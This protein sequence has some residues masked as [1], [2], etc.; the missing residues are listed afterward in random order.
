MSPGVGLCRHNPSGLLP[1]CPSLGKGQ[2][3]S[4]PRSFEQ[5]FLLPR[6]AKFWMCIRG[7][8]SISLSLVRALLLLH[9]QSILAVLWTKR[10]AKKIS[11]VPGWWLILL[12]QFIAN[13]KVESASPCRRVVI[14]ML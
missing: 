12:R 13:E 10:R 1:A 6:G 11:L 4:W 7:L 3:Q 14:E 2:K 9:G 5:P 8:P